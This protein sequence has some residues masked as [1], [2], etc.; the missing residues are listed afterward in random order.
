MN[1]AGLIARISALALLLAL[2]LTPEMFK[3]ALEPLTENGA[4]GDE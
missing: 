3:S 4:R 1:W 2:I